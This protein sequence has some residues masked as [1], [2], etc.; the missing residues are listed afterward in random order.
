MV[1]AVEKQV[2]DTSLVSWCL[3][4]MN[5]DS[6]VT[7]FHASSIEVPPLQLFISMKLMCFLFILG[8]RISRWSD[9]T[10]WWV[11]NFVHFCS[12]DQFPGDAKDS[13]VSFICP[14]T[15]MI[16]NVL[17]KVVIYS[18]DYRIPSDHIRISMKLYFQSSL[19]SPPSVPEH[20]DKSTT[21]SS[22]HT[23]THIS[24]YTMVC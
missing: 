5:G 23:Q 12:W 8:E 22:N 7:E 18:I 2:A 17:N 24:Q 19:L 4:K 16:K 3:H 6:W 15:G 9:V 13:Q 1:F 21:D 10:W 11:V 14:N 20:N